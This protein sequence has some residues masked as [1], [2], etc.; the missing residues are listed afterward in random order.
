[1][2][3]FSPPPRRKAH[4]EFL[5]KKG[6]SLRPLRL[7]GAVRKDLKMNSKRYYFSSLLNELPIHPTVDNASVARSHPVHRPLNRAQRLL[8]RT[9]PLVL[10]VR[11][12]DVVARPSAVCQVPPSPSSAGTGILQVARR[13]SDDRSSSFLDHAQD[14]PLDGLIRHIVDLFRFGERGIRVGD[15]EQAVPFHIARIG[16]SRTGMEVEWSLPPF[17]S[18]IDTEHG[19][20]DLRMTE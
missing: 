4:K 10:P 18:P 6:V 12:D 7:C 15:I 5:E 8:D 11:S 20:R 14:C 2:R 17:A 13:G 19:V 16:T 9:R 1:M 3:L